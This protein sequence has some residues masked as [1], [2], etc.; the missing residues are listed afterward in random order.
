MPKEENNVQS[1]AHQRKQIIQMRCARFRGGKYCLLDEKQ[2]QTKSKFF[3]QR[4]EEIP[5]ISQISNQQDL[6]IFL[7]GHLYEV[8]SILAIVNQQ[9]CVEKLFSWQLLVMATQYFPK[10]PEVA[11]WWPHDSLCLSGMRNR[12]QQDTANINKKGNVKLQ[13]CIKSACSFLSSMLHFFSPMLVFCWM[14]LILL[15]IIVTK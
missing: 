1:E 2:G 5:F 9:Q 8:S 7:R 12:W 10:E 14:K 6:D 15:G 13:M 11:S 4:G 3:A